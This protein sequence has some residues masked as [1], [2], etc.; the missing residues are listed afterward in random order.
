MKLSEYISRL[1]NVNAEHGDLDVVIADASVSSE[2]FVLH[3][4]EA[5]VPEIVDLLRPNGL[6]FFAVWRPGK[7][8]RDDQRTRVESVGTALRIA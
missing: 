7:P 4:K 5:A 3:V 6:D 1:Q 8:V 2:P